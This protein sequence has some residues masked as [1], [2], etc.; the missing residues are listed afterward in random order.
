MSSTVRKTSGNN[1]FLYFKSDSSWQE[2]GFD[3]I[4]TQYHTGMCHEDEFSC[5]NGRCVSSDLVC[6]GYNPCG[7][8]SDCASELAAGVIAGI[9]VGS[10]VFVICVM[11]LILC[12]VRVVRRRRRQYDGLHQPVN[13]VA[14][15]AYGSDYNQPV[16]QQYPSMPYPTGQQYPNSQY[17]NQT[18]PN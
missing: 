18:Y 1:L 12:R 8:Y 14:T 6:N 9:V 2:R 7:D 13:V 17:P 4:I 11:C 3:M 10:F 16:P 15:T 5:S